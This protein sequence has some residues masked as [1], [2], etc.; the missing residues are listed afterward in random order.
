MYFTSEQVGICNL[1]TCYAYM[2]LEMTCK[3]QSRYIPMQYIIILNKILFNSIRYVPQIHL[4][5]SSVLV[6]QG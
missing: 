1:L 4:Q 6:N 5:K 2:M 3:N